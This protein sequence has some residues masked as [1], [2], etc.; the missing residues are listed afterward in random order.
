MRMILLGIRTITPE[1]D[2]CQYKG[3]RL[4]KVYLIV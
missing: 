1:I 2:T 4:V 3:V